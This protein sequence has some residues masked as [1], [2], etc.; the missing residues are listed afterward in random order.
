MYGAPGVP[1][2]TP[3]TSL[4]SA[5]ILLIMTERNMAANVSGRTRHLHQAMR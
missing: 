1:S 5:A 3:T 4:E 2:A